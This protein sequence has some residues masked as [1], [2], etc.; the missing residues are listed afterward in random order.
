MSL[1]D[2]YG[3]DGDTN[4]Y[5]HIAR[6]LG[7][8]RTIPPLHRDDLYRC[9]RH[10]CQTQGL[11]LPPRRSASSRMVDDYLFQAGVS[12]NQLP[13]LAQAF[14]RAEKM[15][16]LPQSDDTRQV[17]D[18]EDRAV[19][20]AP[21]GMTVLR[22][23]VK[24]DP[25]GFHATA[26][27]NLRR[28]T[29]VSAASA[30]ESSFHDAIQ[31]PANS[32][33]GSVSADQRPSLEFNDGEL[34][35]SVHPGANA[36][37]VSVQHHVHRLSGGR[38][39]ALPLP[40]PSGIEWR[41][42][43]SIGDSPEWKMFPIFSGPNRILVF[44]GDS[45]RLKC[46][47]NPARPSERN[48]PAGLI[49]L[50]A[51]SPFQA[52]GE[53]S[54]QLGDS[55]FVLY[56]EVYTELKIQI[57]NL[58]FNFDV[59][60]R[61]RLQVDGARIIRNQDAWLLAQPTAVWVCGEMGTASA[62]LEVRVKHS[63][64]EDTLR[65]PVRMAPDGNAIA[66]L[67]LP[68][69]GEFDMARVSLHVQGQE[70]ALYSHKFWFW[71][72]LKQI[73]NERLFDAASIPENLSEENLSHIAR[74][75]RGYLTLLEDEAYLK[76]QLSFR[77]NRRIARFDFLPPGE[78]ISV[79]RSDGSERPLRKGTSLT[80]R[81]DYAS[82]LIVRCSDPLSAID[83][84]GRV[85]PK[86]F[87]KIGYWRV[88]FATLTEDGSHNRVRLLRSGHHDAAIDLVSIVPETEPKS[89]D[90]REI[91]PRQIVK[92]SFA[93]PVDAIR[94]D[95]ENLISGKNIRF[96][97]TLGQLLVDAHYLPPAKAWRTSEDGKFVRIELDGD[98]Y[99]DG[100]WFVELAIRE[101]GRE[102][103]MPLIN[104]DG[105]SY[106]FCVAPESYRFNLGPKYVTEWR[107]EGAADIF[108]RLSRVIGIPIANECREGVNDLL[109]EA[110]RSLGESLSNGSS[111]D[112]A[113]LLNACAIPPSAHAR[114][115]WLPRHH[116]L[117]VAP[118]LFAAPAEE[119]GRLASS[120]LVGY[121]AFEAVGLAGITESLDDARDLL[122][123]SPAF[124]AAF[125]NAAT[126]ETAANVD[127]GK[128]EFPKYRSLA[129]LI[130]DDGLLSKRCH[131]RFCERMAD[132]FATA[133]KSGPL[134]SPP[135]PDSHLM[136][137]AMATVSRFSP[138]PTDSLAVPQELAE[139]FPPIADIPRLISALAHASRNGRV[140][141]FWNKLASYTTRS[142]EGVRKDVGF[143]LRIAPELLAF[144]LLF[145]ELVERNKGE[146]PT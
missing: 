73:L 67:S 30:F 35:L 138:H 141:Q 126:T 121:D 137:K 59:D 111:A 72:G 143:V 64:L 53:Q 27:V 14:L 54:H 61:L 13:R 55:E 79:R 57:D 104:S 58:E 136:G 3:D 77:V 93:R 32:E 76:A 142:P 129:E 23:I 9:F 69:S 71:P 5:E 41:S 18:W 89:F 6:N 81:D 82:S 94:I 96:E 16:G 45:G 106:A 128:F 40:W 15:F 118:K 65:V 139:E 100:V 4:V 1:A 124:V 29:H 145:W 74:N 107:P 109:L 37:D 88:S 43:H 39:L 135:H 132:R 123:I 97:I 144:Y 131:R 103:W 110:W 134:L 116:P 44:D 85:I 125:S 49:C 33:R 7:M 62:A 102:E 26:F 63:A 84:K 105:E 115:S 80:V 38:N 11:A 87:G 22:R 83:L 120:E 98:N 101:E 52:N 127:P 50:L 2:S 99:S 108:V 75:S 113:S 20:F 51:Q 140:D 25:T 10:A 17:D 130:D 21:P 42:H 12:R 114:E 78:S 119:F 122:D 56:C 31:D 112:Q 133:A 34:R 60:P 86:A 90:A 95:A 47:L 28:A 8:G 146:C 19:E 48:P 36:L 46:E 24:E 70:R 66:Q 91:G 92:A 68:D 117:E